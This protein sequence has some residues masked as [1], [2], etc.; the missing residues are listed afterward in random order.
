[1]IYI[2]SPKHSPRTVNIPDPFW[3]QTTGKILQGPTNSKHQNF[4]EDQ[5]MIK[6]I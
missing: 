6:F 4:F 2:L 1:M 5:S 3:N